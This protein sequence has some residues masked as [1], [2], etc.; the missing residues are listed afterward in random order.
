M[1]NSVRIANQVLDTDI[2]LAAAVLKFGM[3]FD[4]I[5]KKDGSFVLGIKRTQPVF[6][7]KEYMTIKARVYNGAAEFYW[8]SYDLDL[9]GMKSDLKTR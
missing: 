5:T 6:A 8:G 7:D 3:V 9:D 1:K 4:I 2:I